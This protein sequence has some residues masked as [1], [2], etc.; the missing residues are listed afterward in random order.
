MRPLAR[1]CNVDQP[2][3]KLR[4]HRVVSSVRNK[5]CHHNLSDHTALTNP[6]LEPDVRAKQYVAETESQVQVMIMLQWQ[7]TLILMKDG[8]Y[9]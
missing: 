2:V 6:Q 7:K 1:I 4:V 9:G 5:S 3:Q 8:I